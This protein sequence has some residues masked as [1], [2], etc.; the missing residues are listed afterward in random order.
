M[1]YTTFK[2]VHKFSSLYITGFIVAVLLWS[3]SLEKKTPLNRRL[4]N[5]TAHYNI[6]FNARQ[7]L[8]Q[9]QADY[10][11]SFVDDY[12]EL[13]RVYR[14]TAATVSDDKE[15][16]SV[17][18]KARKIISFKE[19]SN[20]VGDAYL[21]L[22]KAYYL[23]KQYFNALEYCDYVLRGYAANADLAQEA[24]VWKARSL[25]ML[26]QDNQA[27]AVLDTALAA[28]NPKKDI[29]ADVYATRLQYELNAGIY[30]EAEQLAAKAIDAEDDSK[31]RLR[32]RFILAQLQELN[33]KPAE[34]VQ[35]YTRI[36]GSNA[37]FEM[38]FNAQL[39]RIR[40]EDLANGVKESRIER[41]KR[42]LRNDNNTDFTD[43]IYYQ[44]AQLLQA[45]KKYDEA[46]TNYQLSVKGSTRN[47]TQKGL[48]YLRMADIYFNNKADYISAKKYY[49]STLVTLPPTYSSYASIQNKTDNLQQL[50]ASLTTIARE[51]TLQMLARLPQEQRQ[52][53]LDELTAIFIKN[54][55][56]APSIAEK[57]M[58]AAGYNN[59]QPNDN[60]KAASVS[61]SSFYFYNN[62]AVS[63]GF[64]SFKQR[65]GNRKLE[66]NWR[67]SQRT[68]TDMTANSAPVVPD[69][70]VPNQ[71]QQTQTNLAAGNYRQQLEAAIP[72]T[73]AMLEQSNMRIF[74]ARYD[75]A[76]FYRDVVGDKKEAITAFEKL[77]ETAQQNPNI[78]GIYYSLYRLHTETGNQSRADYYKNLLL[79]NFANSV[80]ARV[81]TDPD[82]A[83]RVND[84]DAEFN[85][86]YNKVYD[87]YAQRKYD[88]VMQQVDVLM[89]QYPNNKLAAQ[90]YYLR[91]LAHGHSVKLA[92]F[93]TDLENITVNYPAD[94]LI[95]PL[96]SQHLG[97][98][99]AHTEEM[100]SRPV[101]LVDSDPDYIPFKPEEVDSLVSNFAVKADERKKPA[102]KDSVVVI[103]KEKTP[104]P[105]I[106]P[107]TD[108]AAIT[109][110]PAKNYAF[111]EADSSNYYFTVNVNTRTTNL[112]SSRF[113]IGQFNRTRYAG[114]PIRHFLKI[115]GGHQFI[116]VGR[117]ANLEQAKNYARAIVPLLPEIMKVP[118]DK[119]TFF[120][121]T[122]QN[123]DKLADDNMLN[124]YIKYY[125]DTF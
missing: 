19:Q 85:A 16:T 13:L 105:V 12:S 42:L 89:Q 94:R 14:D 44:I 82:Y 51:D 62:A 108:S 47:N 84:A 24:R 41:L 76:N 68:N 86:L 106:T 66:D 99:A 6:V 25:L 95:T 74:N 101:V 53:K 20:Y 61:G 37:S 125:E 118:A 92:P 75:I 79:N 103:A 102:Q 69:G 59:G 11:A 3:C 10:A 73:S 116:Y 27:R 23:N 57:P 121:I 91:A 60:S 39:N 36:A 87:L 17:M 83:Q 9:K 78:A 5:L 117:F 70:A 97:Y 58:N 18:E 4:Q 65:W 119:Y 54:Q 64:V 7:L 100:Q 29:T 71:I 98:I 93:K 43:Q 34:A 109:P 80:Y 81:I 26:N 90:L 113:G 104:E 77:A 33:S 67:R 46:I 49:D 55:P 50:T 35:N 31:Q 15:L 1:L 8:Q 124:E 112:S 96:V 56:V 123:L 28:I 52:Q 30:L 72:L 114:Q 40:I 115:A 111:N 110:K 45:E 21:L 2:P 107:K 32:L 122:K 22:G 120:I 63:A 48:S 88:Q 38:A